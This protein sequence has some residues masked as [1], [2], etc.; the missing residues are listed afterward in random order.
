MPRRTKRPPS[1]KNSAQQ[2]NN[3]EAQIRGIKDYFPPSPP[4]EH[5]NNGSPVL[6]T[7]ALCNGGLLDPPEDTLGM[8]TDACVHFFLLF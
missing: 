4:A 7:E 3:N 5:N 1:K 6:A 2:K 8:R